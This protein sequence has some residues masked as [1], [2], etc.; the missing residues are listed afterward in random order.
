MRIDEITQKRK[1][2]VI[3]YSPG[4]TLPPD[5][6]KLFD[7]LG[8]AQRYEGPEQIMN[9]ITRAYPL[10]WLG[11][12]LEHCGD[13]IHATS[14]CVN[15]DGRI[16][17]DVERKLRDANHTLSNLGPN[18]R[19]LSEQNKSEAKKRNMSEKEYVQ[20]FLSE[21]EEYGVAH[22]KLPAYNEIHQLCKQITTT[23]SAMEFTECLYHVKTMLSYA[24]DGSLNQRCLVIKRDRQG[25]I[26][27][28]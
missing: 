22:Y 9:R 10:M 23:L 17:R 26:L 15:F 18:L 1:V 19:E 20:S 24:N 6:V 3:A 11:N 16:V 25:N 7:E 4:D 5:M 21:M 2:G 14:D 28:L 13:L 8:K 27:R 12:L